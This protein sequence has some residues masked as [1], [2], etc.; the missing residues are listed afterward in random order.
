MNDLRY[1]IRMLGK[2]PVA[3]FAIIV[4]IGLLV[5]GIATVYAGLRASQKADMPFPKPD[6]VV[7]LWRAKID[8]FDPWL[9]A[10]IFREIRRN[11]KSFAELGAFYHGSSF[12]LTGVGEVESVQTLNVTASVPRLTGFPPFKGRYFTEEEQA[13]GA[14]V[15]LLKHAFWLK[16]FEGDESI[17]GQ[18]I[19]L[20]DRPFTVIGVLAPELDRSALNIFGTQLWR[21]REFRA[22]GELNGQPIDIESVYA[23]GRI[24]EGVTLAAASAEVAAI[25]AEIERGRVQNPMEKQMAPKGYKGAHVAALDKMLINSSQMSGELVAM[26]TFIAGVA[27]CVILIACFN[28]TNLLLIRAGNRARETAIRA[29]LGAARS[30]LV[31]QFLAETGLL[32]LLGGCAGLVFAAWI[33]AVLR[34]EYL[35]PQFDAG[36]FGLAFAAA[37]LLGLGVGIVP[38][39]RGTRFDLS[40]ALKDGGQTSGGRQRHRLRNFL[41]AAQVG[42]AMVLCV[43]AGLMTKAFFLQNSVKTGFVPEHMLVLNVNLRRDTYKS[44]EDQVA[45]ANRA[46]RSVGEIPGVRD[47]AMAYPGA[48]FYWTYLQ[49]FELE[50]KD[51]HAP[52]PVSAKLLRVTP[53]FHRVTAVTILRGRELSPDSGNAEPEAVVTQSFADTHF[54]GSDALG[55][56][57]KLQSNSGGVWLTIVGIS[58]KRPELSVAPQG[59][60]KREEVHISFRHSQESSHFQMLVA[61]DPPAKPMA[62]SIR[63]AVR[64]LDNNQ[65][66]PAPATVA[67]TMAGERQGTRNVMVLFSA[68][69]SCGLFLTVL[70]LYAVVSCSVAERTHEIG[71]RLAVGA[72]RSDILLLLLRQGLRLM[73]LGILPGLLLAFAITRGL[74]Q[75][76]LGGASATD[77]TTYVAVV[78]VVALTGLLAS[79]IPAR[80]AARV[81]P[82]IALRNE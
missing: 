17:V 36:L 70:G 38:A 27:L 24:R 28:V 72:S 66:I 46:W 73:L 64:A 77:P 61:T 74:P 6:Q 26:W 35:Q 75:M 32:G 2:H 56:R 54:A 5:G 34:S 42:M 41:V 19:R 58:A 43:A 12:T 55:K 1:A 44:Q 22:V 31:R 45:Y 80:R 52:A 7:K 69:A 60:E 23:V 4:T 25:S 11:T 47:A 71:I 18:T 30:R 10:D 29:S 51:G 49:T 20:D 33:M 57:I 37:M 76:A 63:S 78:A 68:V 13:A 9:P 15:V 16:K 8:G 21:P 48:L 65:P 82:M 3:N 79:F 39:F 81:D 14:P 50:A 59:F 53:N 40:R 67:T 62:G